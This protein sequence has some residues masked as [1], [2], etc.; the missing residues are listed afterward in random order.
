MNAFAFARL[1][2]SRFKKL[3]L[4]F[5]PENKLGTLLFMQFLRGI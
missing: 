5:N 2:Q 1:I 3:V 4:N